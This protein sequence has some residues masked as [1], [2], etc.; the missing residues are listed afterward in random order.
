MNQ[1]RKQ[2]VLVLIICMLMVGP[3][4]GWL[5]SIGTVH[6]AGT[7]AGGDGTTGNPFQI[8]T[9]EQF[10]EIRSHSSSHFVLIDDIN[11]SADSATAVW[12]PISNFTGSLDGRDHSITN[13]YIQSLGNN[14][15]L[16]AT[17]GINGSVHNVEVHASQVQGNNN[18]GIV[19]GT[20]HGSIENVSVTGAVYGQGNTGGLIGFNN[21][22]VNSEHRL[23]NSHADVYVSGVN[24]VGG[25][26]GDS[27]RSDIINSSASGVVTG[28]GNH[29]GGLIG[30]NISS[31]TQESHATSQVQG[32]NKVG[33]LVGRSIKSDYS[34]SSATGQ[35]HGAE[36]VGGFIGS[37]EGTDNKTISR[38]SATG[39]VIG[40][41][42][43]G[44]LVGNNALAAIANSTAAGAVNG[45][46]Y[47]GGLIGH[48]SNSAVSDS[49]ASGD[50]TGQGNYVGGLAGRIENKTQI[51]DISN[52][53][54]FGAVT[55]Q[56]YVGGLAGR[57]QNHT[58]TESGDIS[59]NSAYG[60]VIGQ[61]YVGGLIGLVQRGNTSSSSAS[62][63]VRGDNSVGGLVGEYL[64]GTIT[65]S[66]ASGA[67][68]SSSDAGG[69]VGY[70]AD[71]NVSLSFAT[72]DVNGLDY[73]GGLIGHLEDGSVTQSY[74]R[75]NI[76]G[77]TDAGGLIGIS[78]GSIISF[79]FATG[80]VFGCE[81][82]GGL[83]ADNDEGKISNSYA[84]GNVL[85]S[86]NSGPG[87]SDSIGGLV[88]D[89]KNGEIENSYAIGLV[90]GQ[91]DT[92]GGLVGENGSNA[93]GNEGTITNSY[94]D[95]ELSGQSGHKGQ[96]LT[97]DEMK[98]SLNYVGWD[99][100][101]TWEAD[102]HHDGYPYLKGMQ[103]FL[104]YMGND[105][106]DNSE[107]YIS[108]P[109]EIDSL[110]TIEDFNWT[111]A[112]YFFQG[113][114]TEPDGRGVQYEIGETRQLTSNLL[115]YAIWNR[116]NSGTN[117]GAGSSRSNNANLAKL[118]VT[119][120]GV[121][122][123]LSPE[124]ATGKTTSYRAETKSREATI[125]AT[126]SDAWATV[127]LDDAVLDREKTVVLVEGDNVFKIVVKA[128]NGTIQRYSL[129][130]QRIAESEIAPTIPEA[131]ACPF[132]DI[133]GHWAD[134]LICEAF[135]RGIINGH[136]ETR[137]SPQSDITRV[138]FT[139]ILLRTMGVPSSASPLSEQ[140]FIDQDQIPAWAT[141]TVSIAV[142]NG[143][144]NGYPDH[145]LRPL[146]S[147]SRAEMVTMIA[148]AMN[149]EIEQGNTTFNDD[150][151][152]PLWAKG[153]I[154]EAVQ[155]GLVNGREGNRFSPSDPAT[156]AESTVLL[157]R[158]W[159]AL[160]DMQ[161]EF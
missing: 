82:I 18:V 116:E 54:A 94:Y 36:N 102:Q 133:M 95:T 47:V 100:G 9:A 48:G 75:G 44:G 63:D 62:G 159:H 158:L 59:N 46:G 22:I 154:Q 152:I 11:L 1:W 134:Q 42:N 139:A 27:S 20:S 15:G 68:I 135:K 34:D 81:D 65:E 153:Y 144:L 130:I 25:L 64:T 128:E 145:S 49:S 45:N 127:S 70:I 24:N 84:T 17:V 80:S 151:D 72:G 40:T 37:T 122:L 7:F 16:F 14:V 92:I 143:I 117:S 2:G 88:G 129:T 110:V 114:N 8:A 79:S 93:D 77:E 99:F 38:S 19:A 21:Q 83:V 53:S 157:L 41:V 5:A 26:I 119:T 89:N 105:T 90:T 69:L 56:N 161:S 30:E 112:G 31:V 73:T 23:F 149:W 71:G 52:N 103:A 121:E 85:G 108:E 141:S 78:E 147:V 6:A 32:V 137:F 146:N 66:S 142:K 148:R 96:G 28:Q 50:V 4:S 160:D 39:D 140:S 74:A 155:R 67:V 123:A 13:L 115:L 12:E 131:P 51:Y 104:T 98:N 150:A 10:Y 126:P 61:D 76:T 136:S 106:N 101:A 55:G 138:E 113:W 107:L 86:C 156:R 109:Y 29:V 111:R 57:I 60:A 43:V 35:V 97:S 58:A 120:N 33:G 118:I 3:Y 125:E 124:F 132:H 91:T 87:D